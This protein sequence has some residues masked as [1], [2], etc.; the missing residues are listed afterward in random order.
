[1]SSV[2]NSLAKSAATPVPT[3]VTLSMREEGVHLRDGDGLSSL[4]S[5]GSVLVG[6]ADH[7][8]EWVHFQSHSDF[9]A[10]N[11]RPQLLTI[12]DVDRHGHP[13]SL[14]LISLA[15]H[16][17]QTGRVRFRVPMHFSSSNFGLTFTH[18]FN[19]FALQGINVVCSHL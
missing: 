13:T 14:H 3:E 15:A 19:F 10:K 6:N 1:M 8:E 12:T 9:H 5:D 2:L 16:L 17:Q 4:A 11:W 18:P 7:A